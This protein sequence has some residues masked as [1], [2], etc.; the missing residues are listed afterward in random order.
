MQMVK[1][2]LNYVFEQ[3]DKRDKLYT[4]VKAV[5]LPSTV[6]L[7][8][9]WGPI[10]DQGELGACVS[11]SIVYQ[12]RHVLKKSHGISSNLSRLFVH[13]NGR[14]IA[15]GPFTSTHVPNKD[16]GISIRTGF[17][18]VAKY[19]ICDESAWPYVMNKYLER[20]PE[21]VYSQAK[22][23]TTISYY[24][25]TQELSVMKQCLNS[26]YPI[27]FGL[28]LYPGF[29]STAVVQTGQIPDPSPD[30]K[31]IGAHAMTIVGY[32]D[33]T[34]KFIVA[35]QWTSSWGDAGF[36]YISYKYM[37]NPV[38]VRDL[39]SAR[40]FEVG[41]PVNKIQVP[42]KQWAPGMVFTKGDRTQYQGKE[43][44]CTTTHKSIQAWAPLSTASLWK[45][46]N[47]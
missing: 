10:L 4:S 47:P 43:Y 29:M 19:G 20:P 36:C 40:S 26:G 2:T 11:H 34:E 23:N 3:S 7:R 45:P 46:T 14:E 18:A 5:T 33:Q 16:A 37:T 39:W 8:S 38:M 22:L 6:D 12:L 31:S 24:A 13:Y 17:Q 1:Y 15:H 35:N 44:V 41:A 9:Q 32:N 42:A 30:E 27:S 21:S 28:T 25:V